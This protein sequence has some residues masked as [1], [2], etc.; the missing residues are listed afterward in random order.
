MTNI[1]LTKNKSKKNNKTLKRSKVRQNLKGGGSSKKSGKNNKQIFIFPSKY[2]STQTNTDI[3]YKEIGIVHITQ[4]GAINAL[5]G[6]A[7]GVANIFGKG[8]FDTSIYD[9]ARNNA[10]NKIVS[11][12][13]TSN[14]KICNLRMDIENNPQSSSFF[15]HLYGTL[16]ESNNKFA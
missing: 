3:N 14:Q 2:V 15:I 11:Q 8:G 1:K 16:L 7:T 5:R 6:M 12:I 4:S 9:I 10:L 13:N